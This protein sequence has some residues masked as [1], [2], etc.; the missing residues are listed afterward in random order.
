VKDTAIIE[1]VKRMERRN[2]VFNQSWEIIWKSVEEVS[3]VNEESDD[4]EV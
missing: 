3:V 2:Q 4:E 1:R